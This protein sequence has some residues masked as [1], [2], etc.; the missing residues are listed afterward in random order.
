MIDTQDPAAA[1][2][3]PGAT[4]VSTVRPSVEPLPGEGQS[5]AAFPR[6]QITHNA[7]KRDQTSRMGEHSVNFVC[8]G[9]RSAVN[10]SPSGGS[11]RAGW[12]AAAYC[13]V[14]M[15]NGIIF[16]DDWKWLDSP[17]KRRCW[18]QVRGRWPMAMIKFG[19]ARPR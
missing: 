12:T 14:P 19:L 13:E 11:V 18:I 4:E 17:I 10:D 16:K 9:R 1:A 15:S 8:A 2:S 5:A 6:S 3:P 7:P